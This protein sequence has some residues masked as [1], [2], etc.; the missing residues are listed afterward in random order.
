M[1]TCH[2]DRWI[3]E[4]AYLGNVD[5]ELP[6]SSRV[7]TPEEGAFSHSHFP[8]GTVWKAAGTEAKLDTD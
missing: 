8:V 6:C 3:P 1:C 5:G 2:N 7:E 4:N